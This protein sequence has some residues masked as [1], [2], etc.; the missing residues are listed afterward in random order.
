VAAVRSGAETPEVAVAASPEV[1]VLRLAA[2]EVAAVSPRLRMPASV[3]ST[4][5]TKFCA[6]VDRRV[7]RVCR[8]SPVRVVLRV[9]LV[10]LR[11]DSL[12]VLRVVS[13]AAAVVETVVAVPQRQVREIE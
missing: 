5:V 3:H 6:S 2:V 4:S 12:V 10:A 11:V 9:V 13:L 1:A 7:R 8:A